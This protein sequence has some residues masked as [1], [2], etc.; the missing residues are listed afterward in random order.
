MSQNVQP[1]THHVIN[2]PGL[3]DLQFSC[4]RQSDV[5][6]VLLRVLEWDVDFSTAEL[7]HV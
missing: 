2:Y 5:E 3:S 6:S 1:P 4:E 7:F